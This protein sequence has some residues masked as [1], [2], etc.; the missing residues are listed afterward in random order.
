MSRETKIGIIVFFVLLFVGA[1]ALFL[2]PARLFHRDT[3]EIHAVFD[4]AHGIREN[5]QVLYAGVYVGNVHRIRTENGKAVLDLLI[6]KSAVIPQ[7]ARFTLDTSG[8]VG[9][10]YVRISG[11]RPG[12]Q[13]LH[14]GMTVTE[15]KTDRMD[16]LMEKAG[17]L[18]DTAKSLQENIEAVG[19]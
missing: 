18:M 19:K 1:A 16:R 7:D 9:D 8:V 2:S 5:A 15:Y 14:E 6:K 17:K 3:Y 12:S 10:L 4:D 13:P 11:G